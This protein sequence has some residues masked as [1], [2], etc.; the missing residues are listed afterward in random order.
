M[1]VS[2]KTN[3]SLRA[4]SA[5]TVC[6]PSE[7]SH[8]LKKQQDPHI[9]IPNDVPQ[10]GRRTCYSAFT[11]LFLFPFITNFLEWL[12]FLF[13]FLFFFFFTNHFLSLPVPQSETVFSK[14]ASDFLIARSKA[15]LYSLP[16][17]CVTRISLSLERFPCRFVLLHFWLRILCSLWWLFFL[18][19]YQRE[20]RDS[21]FG[22][23]FFYLYS[24]FLFF[25]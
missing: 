12:I 25:P 10:M 11:F 3:E 20:P 2:L 19:S 24:L 18:L 8:S 13:F 21:V 17:C 1:P 9:G 22:L 23:L 15:S 6:M 4:Y 5:G 14:V 7:T 16:L